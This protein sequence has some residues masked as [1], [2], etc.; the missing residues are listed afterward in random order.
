MGTLRVNGHGRQIQGLA[1]CKNGKT[2][3]SPF[4]HHIIKALLGHKEVEGL[5]AR[6][7]CVD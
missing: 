5:L 4:A 7:D 6:Y 2:D 3:R 1:I